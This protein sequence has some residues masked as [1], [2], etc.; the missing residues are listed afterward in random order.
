MYATRNNWRREIKLMGSGK[1]VQ[2]YVYTMYADACVSTTNMR[3][4]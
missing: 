1:Y 3:R 2:R 4:G